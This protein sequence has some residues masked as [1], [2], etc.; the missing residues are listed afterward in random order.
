MEGSKLEKDLDKCIKYVYGVS[1][2]SVYHT[3]IEFIMSGSVSI[4]S[5]TE[6]NHGVTCVPCMSLEQLSATEGRRRIITKF[7][8]F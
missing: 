5:I 7:M 4:H 6:R 8:G 2:F 3:G 1:L